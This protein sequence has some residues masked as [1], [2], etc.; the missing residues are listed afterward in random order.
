MATLPSDQAALV[1][2][3][4]FYSK[5]GWPVFPVVCKGKAPLTERGL[6]DAS[7]D[8][9]QIRAWWKRWPGANIGCPCGDPEF[10]N[11]EGTKGRGSGHDAVDIEPA[12][13]KTVA[14][15]G[16]HSEWATFRVK[17]PSGGYHALVATRTDVKNAVKPVEGI[18][19][20]TAGGYTLLPPSYVIEEEKGYDG[21]Y[22]WQNFP[23]GTKLPDMPKWLIDACKAVKK[24]AKVDSLSFAK[25]ARNDSLFRYGC[26][27]KAEGLD[28]I[29]IAGALSMVNKE[30]CVPPLDIKELSTVVGSVSKYAPGKSIQPRR[31]IAAPALLEGEFPLSDA[32][33]AERLIAWFG[34]DLRFVPAWGRWLHWN[35]WKWAT[36]E[37]SNAVPYQLALRTVRRI[38]EQA[39]EIEDTDKRKAL[40]KW[41]F[42]CETKGKLEAMV[43][44]ASKNERV[45]VSTADLDAHHG[46][47]NLR[48][49][50]YDLEHGEL[51]EHNKN[52]L[53][54]NGIDIE[55]DEE[56][57]CP[58]WD[59][60]LLRVMDERTE[61][62]NYLA[63]AIGYSLSGD[64][65]EQTFFFLHGP[66]GNNGK[67]TFI[68]TIMHLMGDYAKETPTETLMAKYGDPGISNDLARLKDARFVAAPETE[69]GKRLN[70][71]L[72]KRLTGGD[73]ITARFMRA[74]FFDFRPQFKIWITGNHRPTIKGT[75]DAI[76]RRVALV[77]FDVTIPESERDPELKA[78]LTSELPGILAWAIR[79]YRAWR[80]ERLGKPAVLMMAVED[81]RE[82]EDMLGHFLLECTEKD[83]G[84]KVQ[85][86]VLYGAYQAWSKRSGTRA[87]NLTV[88]GEAMRSRG[89]GSVDHRGRKFYEGRRI[90]EDSWED[91]YRGGE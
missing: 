54:T 13:L 78:K 9:K 33:N 46:L 1:E 64:V 63:K 42:G 8:E 23:N 81:Y 80:T 6:Y 39:C 24:T 51:L 76:W 30:R 2:W 28:D 73:T 38:Q 45:V 52:L 40:A 16:D 11:G 18:D 89:E 43:T 50:V 48:N 22:V 91:V 31:E 86:S 55:Y 26:K 19:I 27:L 35:G 58:T 61:L 36:D 25:G 72:I 67:S 4:V 75:D 5:N 12:G 62:T 21:W 34:E 90:I 85:A 71:G 87:A 17:T 29:E 15:R 60:F 53:L 32:G 84:M 56:A 47:L 37:V 69:D 65:S 44:L 79:G 3:A 14:E 77:P 66:T 49:G 83:S 20:R 59:K 74:E 7:T 41:G 70:E 88:F 57:K 82:S 10:T 68:E